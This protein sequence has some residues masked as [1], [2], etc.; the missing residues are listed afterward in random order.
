MNTIKIER[1]IKKDIQELVQNK[2]WN[3]L[4]K[5]ERNIDLSFFDH[6]TYKSYLSGLNKK[7]SEI[8]CDDS[9]MGHCAK[10]QLNSGGKRFRAILAL[11]ASRIF[12]LEKNVSL[13]IAMCCEFIHNASLI[14]DDLQDRDLL[15]RGLPTIWNRFG[16]HT[17][18]NLGDY[19]ISASFEILS[20]VNVEP[21][22]KCKAI[23]EL[24]RTIKQTVKGQSIEILSRSDFNLKMQDY[25][26]TSR[27]K[28]GGLISL[29]VKLSLILSG[30]SF[31]EK[32][33]KPLYE[34][35]VAYQIQDDL[36]DFL[37]IKDRGLPGRD[38][39]EGKMNILIMHF[40][41]NA[42]QG[43]K[44]ILQKFLK[45]RYDS[46]S[47]DEISYWLDQIKIKGA[48]DLSFT[49]LKKVSKK[50]IEISEKTDKKLSQ[51][52]KFVISSIITR[53][54]KNIKYI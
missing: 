30:N 20:K 15:R 53:I 31:T 10:Y 11:L 24:S 7:M 6:S 52:V 51:I 22:L 3:Q 13:N 5:F 21:K 48:L 47:E 34:T 33:F 42:T 46:I 35:G 54:T 44:F 41:D 49:H 43:E 8:L 32:Y 50:A 25:E 9:W 12:G 4:Y 16:D 45:K 23:E 36:S 38:L 14:H 37:G 26:S 19:F 39:K 2:N 28:T 18:I 17:A 40:I 27:A 29:P 1:K